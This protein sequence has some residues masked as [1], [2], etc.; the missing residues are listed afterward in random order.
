MDIDYHLIKAKVMAGFETF[1][2]LP[3]YTQSSP[4]RDGQFDIQGASGIFLKQIAICFPTGTKNIKCLQR[5]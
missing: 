3:Q 4:V 2:H 5:S 1:L